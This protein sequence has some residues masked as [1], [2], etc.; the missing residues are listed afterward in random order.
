MQKQ[1]VLFAIG[2]LVVGLIVGFMGAN[3]LNRNSGS[4]TPVSPESATIAQG[5]QP[6]QNV[7]AGQPLA[8]V[9]EMIRRAEAEPQ[10]FAVQMRTGDMYAQIGRFEK[11]IEF[12]SKG[13]ALRPDDF[14][15]NVVLANAYFDSGSF[16]KAG[17]YYEKALAADPKDVNARSDLGATFVERPSPD[18]DRAISE[19]NT[20]LGTEPAH[21]PSL[22][23]LAVAQLRKGNATEA[24][25]T[26]SKLEQANPNS[27]LV[28]RLRQQLSTK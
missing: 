3:S 1:S 10:N 6:N 23:Y 21:A 24:Q 5:D 4:A 8:D 19:F 2:G 12:Y 17:D 18:Y 16:E 22:Y 7:A 9:S 26:L 25:K 15:A 27:D 13:V 20:A 14:K 28:N 11:A